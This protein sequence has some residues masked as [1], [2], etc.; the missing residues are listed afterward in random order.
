[1]AGT[2]SVWLEAAEGAKTQVSV[3]TRGWES[4]RAR[5][6]LSSDYTGVAQNDSTRKDRALVFFLLCSLATNVSLRPANFPLA[7]V[8]TG[9]Y[10]I[11]FAL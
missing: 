1:M 7:T 4:A 5:E 3:D 2:K 10:D 11:L 8:S 6:G 9:F